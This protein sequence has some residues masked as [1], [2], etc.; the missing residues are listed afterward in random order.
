[1]STAVGPKTTPAG[2]SRK[3]FAPG[4]EAVSSVPK[5][6]DTSPPVTRLRIFRVT[7]PGVVLL[8]SAVSAAP[9]LKRPKL[10]N[11]FGP[12]PGRAPPVIWYTVPPAPGAVTVVPRPLEVIAVGV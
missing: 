12:F 10:W 8:K 1:M 3:K 4:Y 2:L 9:M 5:M 7:R 11:R 6:L